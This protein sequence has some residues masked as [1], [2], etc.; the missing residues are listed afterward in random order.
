MGLVYLDACTIIYCV[1]K[2]YLYYPKLQA[3]VAAAVNNTLCIS[4]LVKAE[5]L[6]LP[7]RLN[8]NALIGLY[9][10]F[11]SSLTTLTIDETVFRQA[12]SIRAQHGFKLPDALHLACAIHHDCE[13]FWTNDLR[14][15]NG[16]GPMIVTAF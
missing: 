4:P 11:F 12:A 6:V 5:C 2:S 1:E 3:A 9:E 13:A 16:A 7:I 8:N 10:D 14:L 15:S